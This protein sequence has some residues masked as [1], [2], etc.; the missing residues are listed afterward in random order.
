MASKRR[1]RRI[2]C[3]RKL[4][5]RSAEIALFN[6]QKMFRATGESLSAFRCKF[7]GQWHLGHRPAYIERAIAER[8]RFQPKA[9]EIRPPLHHRDTENTESAQG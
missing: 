2:K 6:A 4:Q 7:C 8:H 5:F 3:E 1:Q 9:S